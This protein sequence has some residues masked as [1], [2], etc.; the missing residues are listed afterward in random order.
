M[1]RKLLLLVAL[2]ALLPVAS[3]AGESA[4]PGADQ[5]TGIEGTITAGPSHGGPVREGVPSTMPLANMTFDVKQGEKVIT[6]FTTDGEGHFK[7]MLPPGQYTVVRSGSR[8]AVG[9]YGPFEVT[10]SAGKMSS[11]QWE[12]DPGLR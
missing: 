1:K 5:T 8:T 2:G 12:C 4:S 10:V 9:R 7:V 3:M 11:V 6:S